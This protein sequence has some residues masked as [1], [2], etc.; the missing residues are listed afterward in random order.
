MIT[1]KIFEKQELKERAKQYYQERI[2]EVTKE[3]EDLCNE[4]NE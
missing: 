2:T 3:I 1:D 4:E